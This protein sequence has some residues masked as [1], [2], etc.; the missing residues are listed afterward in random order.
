MSEI[1]HL[2]H[3]RAPTEEFPPVKS[4]VALLENLTRLARAGRLRGL[5]VAQCKHADGAWGWSTSYAADHRHE[6]LNSLAGAL[7]VAQTRF[8]Q[9][10]F[11]A[12]ALETDSFEDAA[13]VA[14]KDPR[15]K[16][17]EDS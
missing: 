14:K 11:I 3:E 1:V 8:V 12:T 16:P 10:E 15:A 2:A 17:E 6:T 5:I 13:T 9:N 7:M 4:V